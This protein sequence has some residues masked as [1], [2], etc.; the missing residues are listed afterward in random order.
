[1]AENG[2]YMLDRLNRLKK[3]FPLIGDIRG[4][5]FLWGIELVKDQLTKEKATEEAEKILYD[6]MRNGLSFKVSQGNVLQLSPALTISHEELQ[7]ALSILMV[8]FDKYSE[9]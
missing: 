1:M 9:H 5:G 4:L 6:C 7:T 3:Q 8:V 2:S